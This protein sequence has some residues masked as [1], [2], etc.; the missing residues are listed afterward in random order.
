MTPF[1]MPDSKVVKITAR[2]ALRSKWIEA[3]SASFLGLFAV[4]FVRILA[5]ILMLNQDAGV[6]IAVVLTIVLFSVFAISPLFLGIVRFFWRLTDSANDP[7]SSVFFYFGR[8]EDYL[9]SVK[10]TFIMVWRVF[11]AGFLCM[12]PYAFINIIS[13]SWFY[14]FMGFEI[15]L[16]APNLVLFESVL[17]IGGIMAAVLYVSRYYLVPV[18]VASNDDLLLLEAVHISCMVSKR[19]VTSF[20]WLSVSLFGWIMLTVLLLPA[21]YTLPLI[22]CCYT[23]HSRFAMVNYNLVMEQ[24]ENNAMG[25]Y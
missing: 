1:R 12:M 21:I 13:G 4:I 24:S 22:L 15:P 20:L 23:V 7:L 11:I 14:Q 17:Y 8:K 16:W 2:T 25:F 18:L 10:L 3:I 19:S 9:K 6:H 5:S